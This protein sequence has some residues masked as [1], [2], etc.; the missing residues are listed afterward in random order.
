ML[1]PVED[2]YF[3]RAIEGDFRD[4]RVMAIARA[5]QAAA[6]ARKAWNGYRERGRISGLHRLE[7][8]ISEA[9]RQ[10][11]ALLTSAYENASSAMRIYKLLNIED[12]SS[13]AGLYEDIVAEALLQRR[14]LTELAMVLKPS[15]LESKLDL[16]PVVDRMSVLQV[17]VSDLSGP[18]RTG[19]GSRG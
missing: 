12:L 4:Q 19:I 13:L 8:R 16:L 5:D 11:A 9:F 17:P 15:L 18:G 7:E 14:S 6:D 3:V 10:R 2:V 1:D